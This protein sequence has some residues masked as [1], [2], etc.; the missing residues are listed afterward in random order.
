MTK[1]ST[2]RA[3]ELID[4]SDWE[5]ASNV[6]P[7]VV[8]LATLLEGLV[9]MVDD[10][11]CGTYSDQDREDLRS[12]L[13]PHTLTL[14]LHHLADLRSERE[15][16]ENRTLGWPLDRTISLFDDVEMR[17]GTFHP[18]PDDRSRQ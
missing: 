1:P 3:F 10:A 6:R 18:Q 9:D 8:E 7:E 5:E 11:N 14:L 2:T 17:S 12:L 16:Q 15:R 4:I 13:P